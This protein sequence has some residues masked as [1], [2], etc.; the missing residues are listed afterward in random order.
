M[1]ASIYIEGGMAVIAI[2]AGYFLGVPPAE[3]MQ[4]SLTGI[5]IGILATVPMLTLYVIISR[6]RFLPFV[7]IRRIVK[8]FV[9]FFFRNCSTLQIGLICALAGIGEELFFRGLLQAGIAKYIG[10]PTGLVLAILISSI[11]FGLAHFVTKTY[12]VLAFAI[13]V[14][15]GLLFYWTDNI[16]VPIITHAAYDYCVIKYLLRIPER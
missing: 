13:G 9:F 11:V 3:K 6:M 12:A 8:N 16:V 5:T 2:V 14:Y 4:I 1:L 10:G 7:H 15:L